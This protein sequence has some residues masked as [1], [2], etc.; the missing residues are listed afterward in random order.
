MEN[1]IDNLV[2]ELQN[3]L[4]Q[5]EQ[6]FGHSIPLYLADNT[7]HISNNDH[8]RLV[9]F[10]DAELDIEKEDLQDKLQQLMYQSDESEN[11]MNIIQ[12]NLNEITKRNDELSIENI[13][14][15]E[16]LTVIYNKSNNKTIEQQ[17]TYTAIEYQQLEY[18]YAETRSKL[19]RIEQAQD[20]HILAKEVIEKD[21]EIEKSR[22]ILAEK[23][24]D[25]YIAAYEASLKHFE[26]FSRTKLQRK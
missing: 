6:V 10:H 3:E 19:A 5:L 15:K 2:S 13:L 1:D 4:D 17:Q 23:E 9:A 16:K 20:D 14:L 12:M 8:E 21:L 7:T 11:Q 25:A 22:R 18:K 26:K 24:R